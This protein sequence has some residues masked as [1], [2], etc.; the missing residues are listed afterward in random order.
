M[1]RTVD[2]RRQLKFP[3]NIAKT[4]LKPAIVLVF[5]A[6]K[7]IVMLQLTLPWK[8][9]MEETFEW[10]REKYESLLSD[11]PSLAWEARCMPMEALYRGFA[12]QSLCRAY[13]SLGITGER[14]RNDIY[15]NTEAAEKTSRWL[16]IKRADTGECSQG[17]SWGLINLSWVT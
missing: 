1:G 15:N 16:W 12:G 17:A 2:L 11:C 4:T 10:K 14:S 8:H 9:G 7:N 6:S 13:T 3:Q 5:E